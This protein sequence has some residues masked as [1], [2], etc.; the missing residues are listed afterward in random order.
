MYFENL[1]SHCLLPTAHRLLPAA[2]CY[3]QALLHEEKAKEPQLL[4]TLRNLIFRDC[5]DVDLTEDV[6]QSPKGR[7]A[8]SALNSWFQ[9]TKTS[10]QPALVRQRSLT[11]LQLQ[12]DGFDNSCHL[13]SLLESGCVFE[14]VA[15]MCIL[16]RGSDRL[17]ADC[18]D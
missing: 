12:L 11:S 5:F 1:S 16:V 15:E 7:R 4:Q 14:L 8:S 13:G 3:L 2:H 9:N 17:L 10:S 18:T 6:P